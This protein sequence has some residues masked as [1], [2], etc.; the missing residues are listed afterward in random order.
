MRNLEDMV[1]DFRITAMRIG[2]FKYVNAEMVKEAIDDII[3][4]KTYY[5]SHSDSLTDTLSDLEV[6]SEGL[7][8]KLKKY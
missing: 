3:E 6:I 4:R 5:C 1:K 2:E 7:I 8:W